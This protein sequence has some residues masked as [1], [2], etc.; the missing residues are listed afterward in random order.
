MQYDLRN[1]KDLLKLEQALVPQHL[2]DS[3]SPA[4][5][6]NLVIKSVQQ[7]DQYRDNQD[8][9]QSMVKFSQVDTAVPEDFYLRV[10]DLEDQRQVMTSYRAL[11]GDINNVY[12]QIMYANFPL[13]SKEILQDLAAE[14]KPHYAKFSPKR[15]RF[16]ATDPIPFTDGDL[17]FADNEFIAAH[18]SQLKQLEIPK[19][20]D[21][22]IEPAT[23]ISWYNKYHAAC[24]SVLQEQPELKE[25]LWI[26]SR[27]DMQDQVDKSPIFTI[28]I[29]GQW[30]GIIACKRSVDRFFDGYCMMEITIAEAHRGNGYA[31]LAQSEMYKKLHWKED[32]IIWGTIGY[33]NHASRKTALRC[34]RKRSGGYYFAKIQ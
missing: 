4:K 10:I 21:L 31:A 2:R 6:Q 13:N 22:H 32:D 3:I 28:N 15:I 14:I 27:E 30:A 12:I 16:F 26:E 17:I 11:G 23:D 34:G 18:H 7:L 9:G 1:K 33:A 20:L 8:F 29:D 5:L 24:H 25:V 19:E